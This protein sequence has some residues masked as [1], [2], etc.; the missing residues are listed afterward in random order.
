MSDSP[1]IKARMRFTKTGTLRFLGHLDLMRFFQKAIKRA[2]LDVAYSQGFSPHQLLSFASP[3]G[4]GQTTDGDYLDIEFASPIVPEDVMTALNKELNSEVYITDI[5]LMPEGFKNSMSMLY[6][7]DY[8]VTAKSEGAFP[9]DYRSEFERFMSQK[10]IIIHK[11][12]KKS[13]RDVDIKKDIHLYAFD[14]TSFEKC[15][16]LPLPEL[17]PIYTGDS[18]YMRLSTESGNTVRPDHV[19]D[20]FFAF[21][22]ADSSLPGIRYPSYRYAFQELNNVI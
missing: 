5:E 4:V 6:L 15:T 13:E 21:L 11:K 1:R 10:E 12:T 16:G 20:A 8:V 18:I 7:C 17:H 22:S 14:K 19:M 9:A 3:L 2:G